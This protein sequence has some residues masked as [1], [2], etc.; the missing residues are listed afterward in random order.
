LTEGIYLKR[1]T[2]EMEN[3]KLKSY[4]QNYK[5]EVF[6]KLNTTL[7]KRKKTLIEDIEKYKKERDKLK[8]ENKNIKKEEKNYMSKGEMKRKEKREKREKEDE[9]IKRKNEMKEKK[10]KDLIKIKC[11]KLIY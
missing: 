2:N 9:L 6:T 3:E 7:N 4:Y 5:M 10:Y 11:Q 1:I 8:A